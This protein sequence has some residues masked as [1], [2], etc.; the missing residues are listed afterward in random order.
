M[1]LKTIL[2]ILGLIVILTGCE[3]A[4]TDIEKTDVETETSEAGTV[5]T[6]PETTTDECSNEPDNAEYELNYTGYPLYDELIENIMSIYYT[7]EDKQA[8]VSEL[9]LSYIYAWYKLDESYGYAL[10]DLDGDGTQELLLGNIK[11]PEYV[12]SIFTIKNN[13]LIEVCETD[14]PKMELSLCEGGIVFKMFSYNSDY[15]WCC[16]DKYT[17]G[18]LNTIES[19]CENYDQA[20]SHMDEIMGKYQKIEIDYTPLVKNVVQ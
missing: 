3:A 19:I 16:Y 6:E 10:M 13:E 12:A 20:E 18:Q 15:W 5:P 8:A 2:I 4:E 11:L 7:S 14:S 9:G 17:D 1:R